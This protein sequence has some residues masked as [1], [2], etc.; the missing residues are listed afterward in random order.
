M[1]NTTSAIL[2]SV[3]ALSIALV[4]CGRPIG[5]ICDDSGATLRSKDYA[6]NAVF[7]VGPDRIPNGSISPYT[8]IYTFTPAPGIS[9]DAIT[10]V[11]SLYDKDYLFG[12]IPWGET[13]LSTAGGATLGSLVGG[14]SPTLRCEVGEIRGTVGNSGESTAEIYARVNEFCSVIQTVRCE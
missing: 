11:V 12:F 7:L 6:I 1:K 14:A 5:S 8:V 9:A 10:P 13:Q 3:M 4:G 2:T